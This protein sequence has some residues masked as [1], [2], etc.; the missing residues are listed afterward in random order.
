MS[1]STLFCDNVDEI[2]Q[3]LNSGLYQLACGK[4]DFIIHH[5]PQSCRTYQQH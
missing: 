1:Y 2:P 3:E 5:S 4:T